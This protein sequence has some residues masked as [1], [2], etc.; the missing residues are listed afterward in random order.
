VVFVLLSASFASA[1]SFQGTLRGRILD[2]K[3]AAASAVAITLTDE[4]TSIRRQTTTNEQG[5]LGGP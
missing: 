5:E 2:P 3:G 1:Q 4:G